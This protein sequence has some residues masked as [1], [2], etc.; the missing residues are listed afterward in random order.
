MQKR[1]TGFLDWAVER[2]RTDVDFIPPLIARLPDLAAGKMSVCSN[3]LFEA[4]NNFRQR[5][6]KKVIV[7]KS[8]HFFELSSHAACFNRLFHFRFP[9]AFKSLLLIPAEVV[10]RLTPAGE[11]KK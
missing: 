11:K 8:K 10:S 6:I 9:F 3:G 2:G 5:A 1:G 4:D 7:E